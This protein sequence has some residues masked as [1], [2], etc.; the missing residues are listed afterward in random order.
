MDFASRRLALCN[1]QHGTGTPEIGGIP[2]LEAQRLLRGLRGLNLVGG[3]VVGEPAH[4]QVVTTIF[5]IC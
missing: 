5:P 3:D 1:K 2:T 4:S